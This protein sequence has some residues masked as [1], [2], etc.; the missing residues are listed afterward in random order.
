[1]SLQKTKLD[2]IVNF[3]A[4]LLAIGFAYSAFDYAN[5]GNLG[6]ALIFSGGALSFALK[7]FSNMPLA[8]Y[9]LPM[10]EL[11]AEMLRR[12]SPLWM[13]VMTTLCWILVGAGLYINIAGK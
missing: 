10:A 5:K 3:L 8:F 1:M 11:Q 6:N 9:K 13:R 2:H 12:P 7:P 4:S